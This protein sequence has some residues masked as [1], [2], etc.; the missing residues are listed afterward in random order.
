MYL[1]LVSCQI[2]LLLQ[3][4]HISSILYLICF[5]PHYF[6][7]HFFLFAKI[8]LFQNDQ[9]HVFESLIDKFLDRTNLKSEH[10]Y[11]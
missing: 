7:S 1:T 11:K 8:K 3:L 9:S 2:C 5:R 6:P 4:F 10:V